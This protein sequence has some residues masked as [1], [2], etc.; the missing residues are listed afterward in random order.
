MTRFRQ[1]VATVLAVCVGGTTLVQ[2]AQAAVIST[3]QVA[4]AQPGVPRG[5]GR[6][7]L[8]AALDRAD[9]AA[10]LQARGV[11]PDAA[12][13]RVA[14]LTDAEADALAAQID[15]AP[16]GG[17]VLGTI[18]FIFVLLLI[19]DILGFT[20]VYPFTRSIR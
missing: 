7:H 18:V 8:Q 13:Q 11:D 12:R 19:T 17:D 1:L 4:L 3:E 6:A 5:D 2:G 14:A 9:V 20:K 16:A 10:A 15:A